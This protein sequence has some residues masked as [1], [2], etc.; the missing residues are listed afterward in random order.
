MK[1]GMTLASLVG[2]GAVAIAVASPS[3]QQ[4][5]AQIERVKDNLYIC[6]SYDLI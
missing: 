6:T 3:A 5:T 1:R 2:L 4:H